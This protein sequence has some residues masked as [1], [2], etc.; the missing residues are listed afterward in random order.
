[1]QM[2][3]TLAFLATLTLASSAFADPTCRLVEIRFKPMANLQIAAWIED[4]QGNYV[5]TAYITRLATKLDAIL[6]VNRVKV[7]TALTGEIQS[8]LMK[9]CVGTTNVAVIPSGRSSPLK[10]RGGR[11]RGGKSLGRYRR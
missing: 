6:V 7:H 4:T 2:R 1:M 3:S 8:G 9:S 11:G 10:R 5:D